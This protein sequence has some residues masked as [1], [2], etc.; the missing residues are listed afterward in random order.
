MRT[1]NYLLYI[2]LITLFSCEEP[3]L[4]N[5]TR[6][7]P[8]NEWY[9]DSIQQFDFNLQ[10]LEP[11]DVS[12]Y[13]RYSRTYEYNNIYLKGM[14][15]DST[16]QLVSEK[17]VNIKLSDDKTGQPLGDGS[18]SLFVKKIVLIDSLIVKNSG[19]YALMVCHYLRDNPLKEVYDIGCTIDP[20]EINKNTN[21]IPK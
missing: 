9:I 16:D 10:N 4:Y 7:F 15:F 5:Q 12:L 11:I 18:G 13:L 20:H 8:N 3:S 17:L 2:V 1:S 21:S 6:S 19:N 14:L